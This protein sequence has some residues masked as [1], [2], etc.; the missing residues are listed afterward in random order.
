MDKLGVFNSFRH[1]N[2]FVLA[3]FTDMEMACFASRK[4]CTK[5]P[6]LITERVNSSLLVAQQT[7]DERSESR[8]DTARLV[9]G[10]F[11]E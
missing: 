9:A 8:A 1:P 10:N 5:L 11:I 3:Q 6:S 4:I 7:N 2:S